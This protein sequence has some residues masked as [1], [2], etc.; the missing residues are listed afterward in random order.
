[1]RFVQDVI[2]APPV[3]TPEPCISIL[4]LLTHTTGRDQYCRSRKTYG[5]H[6]FD[7]GCFRHGAVWDANCVYPIPDELDS[8]SA[9]PLMCAGAT[10]WSVLTRFRIC[11][12]DRVGVMGKGG[13]GHLAIKLAAA[14]G[15]EV[16]T[17]SGSESK[18]QEA[19]EFGASEYHVFSSGSPPSKDFKPLKHLLL[20]GNVDVDYSS[21]LP[22]IDSC[23]SVYPLTA[24]FEPSGIPTLQF[25]FK[26]I[27][28]QGS[29]VASRDDIRSLLEFA[30]Q[31]KIVP[32]VITFP[33]TIDGI[34]GAMQTLRDGNMRYR[35]VLVRKGLEV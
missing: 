14:M 18:R 27:R 8:V 33:L 34:E 35:G 10:V 2:T 3:M 15:C 11:P 21:L 29:H 16:V 23:G 30:V 20:C 13:L 24:T 5:F 31:K 17:L 32:N 26:G 9:A 1:M 4:K 6:H 19:I 28:I 7:N 22:L 25:A 12:N